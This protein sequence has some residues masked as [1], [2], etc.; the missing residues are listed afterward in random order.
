MNST[1]ITN[2]SRLTPT[3]SRKISGIDVS[4]AIRATGWIRTAFAQARNGGATMSMEDAPPVEPPSSTSL[5]HNHVKSMAVLSISLEVA[6]LA[7]KDM[8]SS[9]TPANCQT[10]SS[11]TRENA[12]SATPT[13]SSNQ[14]ALACPKTSSARR[15][16]SLAPASSV[17]T[18]TTTLKRTKNASK[19]SLAANIA[20][21]ES[22]HLAIT[23]SSSKTA[24]AASRAA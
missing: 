10:A 22:A 6:N 5:N 23:P 2:V 13:M 7:I 18:A 14:T 16:M 21:K 1:P 20:R 3:V 4:S 17:W 24:D 19:R 9:T 12:S 15:W 8:P 11:P